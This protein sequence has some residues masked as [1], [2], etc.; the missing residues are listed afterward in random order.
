MNTDDIA[1]PEISD[2][3]LDEIETAI[4]AQIAHEPR[5]DAADAARAERARVRAVR[6]GRIW[7]GA[8]GAAAFIAVAAIIAPQLGAV[9]DAGSSRTIAQPV[10]IEGAREESLQDASGGAAPDA[11][12]G[13][14]ASSADAADREIIATATAS[15]VAPDAQ[16]AVQEI[17]DAATA[18]GGYVESMS[19]GGAPPV[20]IDTTGGIAPDQAVPSQVVGSTAWIS[21]R[22]PADALTDALAGL[23]GI[24][25]V[26]ASQVDRRDV[27]TEAVDL[28]ARV[29]ALEASV[30]RL[31]ELMGQAASTADLIA[32]ESALAER[33]SELDALRQQLTYLES[34]VGMS[35]LTVAVSEPAATVAADPAGFGDG[36][37]A[38]WNGLVASLNGL[39]VAIGFLLP[40]ALVAAVIVAIVW[41]VRRAARRRKAARIQEDQSRREDA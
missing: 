40:W 3:R 26:T 22:V 30:A 12:T 38:G 37:A 19:V 7:M 25:E 17:S 11:A 29:G 13:S 6:R 35:T 39:V 20:A 9:T 31:T 16:R 24:G 23:S 18:A 36:L 1:L 10:T 4:L 32:A 5:R 2:R 28:R 41:F 8:A 15:I 27:T 33:Q 14:E 21:V 34:Q